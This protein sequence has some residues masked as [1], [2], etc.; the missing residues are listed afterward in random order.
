MK[1]VLSLLCAAVMLISMMAV[2]VLPAAAATTETVVTNHFNFSTATNC[3]LNDSGTSA[4]NY[5]FTSDF[6]E[7]AAGD[8]LY[9]GP[10]RVDQGYQLWA[11]NASKNI[12]VA[13][14]NGGALTVSSTLVNTDPNKTDEDVVIYKWT[15]PEGTAYVRVST[16][17]VF[18]RHYVLTRNE[19]L[20]QKALLN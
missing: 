1:K 18:S 6:I 9:F 3:V 16:E 12:T 2:M 4:N 14:V 5:F 17:S 19:V 10:C 13:N 11:Y 7:V 15:V 20:D 8:T